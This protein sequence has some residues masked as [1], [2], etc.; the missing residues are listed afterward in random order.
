M[1]DGGQALAFVDGQTQLIWAR[2]TTCFPTS[3]EKSWT[4]FAHI[5]P[6]TSFVRIVMSILHSSSVVRIG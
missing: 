5:I 4:A 6:R 1:T 2:S 3:Q